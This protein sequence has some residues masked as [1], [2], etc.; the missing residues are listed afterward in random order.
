MSDAAPG[1][2]SEQARTN[3]CAWK[4]LELYVGTQ[5]FFSD[6]IFCLR[7]RCCARTASTVS[8]LAQ[9]TNIMHGQCA[10][11]MHAHERRRSTT[12]KYAI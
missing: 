12:C 10:W 1:V 6:R 9:Q 3:Q 2:G 11:T 4:H 5:A 8:A 7:H